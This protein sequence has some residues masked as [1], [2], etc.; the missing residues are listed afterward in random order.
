MT[1]HE[2]FKAI[3]RRFRITGVTLEPGCRNAERDHRECARWF[4]HT[5]HHNYTICYARALETLP[6]EFKLG[7]LLHELGHL[8]AGPWGPERWADEAVAD[9]LRIKIRYRNVNAKVKRVEWVPLEDLFA[10]K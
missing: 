10:G 8:T 3:M 6:D 1:V 4:A 9:Q 7:I 2:L 5:W